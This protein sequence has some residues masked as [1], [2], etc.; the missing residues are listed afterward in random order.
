MGVRRRTRIGHGFYKR[1]IARGAAD[2]GK[3]RPRFLHVAFPAGQLPEADIRIEQVGPAFCDLG[4]QHRAPAVPKKDH[5]LL[6][7]AATQ[8]LDERDGVV[9]ELGLGYG[10]AQ[11]FAID[12]GSTEAPLVPL[13]DGEII[14]PRTLEAIGQIARRSARAA[15]KIDEDRLPAILSANRHPLAGTAQLHV[16]RLVDA[17]GRNDARV[18]RIG[19]LQERP[20]AEHR[21]DNDR[22]KQHRQQDKVAQHKPQH[23]P[24]P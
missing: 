3:R 5:L 20:Y 22:K 7:G 12:R 1:C 4:A 23:L 10:T 11:G 9:D 17:A 15:V 13:H 6:A 19:A 16:S 24:L 2:L 21:A 14:L 8:M 18:C